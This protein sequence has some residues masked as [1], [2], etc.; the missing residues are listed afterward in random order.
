MDDV[1]IVETDGRKLV[2][3][4]RTDIDLDSPKGREMALADNATVKADLS[5]DDEQMQAVA[6]EFGIDVKEWDVYPDDLD[7]NEFFEEQKEEYKNQSDKIIVELHGNY[8]KDE[9]ELIRE[10]IRMSLVGYDYT[11]K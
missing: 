9:Q 5:W 7:M 2:A 10:K 3:V 11:I 8:D 6:S 4:K 1:I